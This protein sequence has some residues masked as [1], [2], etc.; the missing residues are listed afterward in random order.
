MSDHCAE[1][2]KVV[3]NCRAA[4][5]RWSLIEKSGTCEHFSYGGCGGTENN[6]ESEEECKTTCN[7]VDE[8]EPDCCP[9]GQFCC[10]TGCLPDGAQT[11][12]PCGPNQCTCK[13]V[14]PEPCI[15]TEEYMPLCNPKTGITYGNKCEA[16]TCGGQNPDDLVDGECEKEEPEPTDCCS[17][18]E[19]CC[20]GGC[21][22]LSQQ[23]FTT[24][25]AGATC[26]Q[27]VDPV[28]IVDCVCSA[29][30]MPVCSKS[31]G[32]Q[33]GNLCEAGCAKDP[34]PFANGACHQY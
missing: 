28:P 30:F 17:A 6:F 1:E 2:P 11:F 5:P 10:G 33:Y 12:A 8:P 23:A 18:D 26:C 31:S 24:C 4:I 25:F 16:V 20:G 22:P 7:V 13:P 14:D 9:E 32:K 19:F 34:G 29:V 27:V 3:G 21:L 15:C